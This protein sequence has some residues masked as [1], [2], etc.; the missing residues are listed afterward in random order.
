MI[1]HVGLHIL[2][3]YFSPSPVP[4]FVGQEADKEELLSWLSW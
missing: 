2:S 1:L 3:L 4:E